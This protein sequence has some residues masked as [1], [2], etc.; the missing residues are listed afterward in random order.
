MGTGRMVASGNTDVGTFSACGLC[1]RYMK[2]GPTYIMGVVSDDWENQM[3]DMFDNVKCVR[4]GNDEFT[5]TGD[6]VRIDMG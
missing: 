1:P 4:T 5:K 2:G 6:D 3:R